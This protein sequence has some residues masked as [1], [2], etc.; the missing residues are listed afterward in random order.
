MKKLAIKHVVAVVIVLVGA[1][2]AC[3]ENE[4]ASSACKSQPD[5]DECEKCCKAQGS[6]GYTYVNGECGCL[7]G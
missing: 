2:L 6:N 3:K 1:L 5:S 4:A 7:G